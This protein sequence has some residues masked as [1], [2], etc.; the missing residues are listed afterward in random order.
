MNLLLWSRRRPR[1]MER[2]L[3]RPKSHKARLQSRQWYG[4]FHYTDNT[5]VASEK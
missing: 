1:R 5:D 2:L 4:A 3:L